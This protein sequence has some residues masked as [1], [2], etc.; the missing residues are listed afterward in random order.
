MGLPDRA[1][2]RRPGVQRLDLTKVR[3]TV[4]CNARQ[5]GASSACGASQLPIPRAGS[6]ANPLPP[7]AMTQPVDSWPTS[8]SDGPAYPAAELEHATGEE[9]HNAPAQG[10]APPPADGVDRSPADGINSH[11]TEDPSPGGNVWEPPLSDVGDSSEDQPDF[12]EGDSSVLSDDPGNDLSGVD[13]IRRG[14]ASSRF[15]SRLELS[16][17]SWYL[18]DSFPGSFFDVA[19]SLAEAPGT[20]HLF[21]TQQNGL[22]LAIS[23]AAPASQ[24]KVVLDLT[25]TTQGGSDCGLLG[26]AFHPEFG[27][28]GSPNRGFM[29][30]H[31]AYSEAPVQPQGA[32]VEPF[33]RTSSR[34]SRFTVNLDTLVAAPASEQI[35]IEQDDENLYHQ[36]GALLFHPQDGFL[37]LTVGDEGWYDCSFSNC[38]RIDKDLFS[39]VLRIDVDQ[40]GGNVSHPIPRQPESGITANYYIPN[41]NPFVGQPGV[42]EEFYALG[43]RSPH[44]M[45]HDP[46]D[47]LVLIGDVGQFL[48]EEVNLLATGANYQWNIREG[49]VA[50][51]G[52]TPSSPIGVWTDPVLE[53]ERAES[54]S[55]IGGYV[56][57]GDR[58]PELWVNTSPATSRPAT[59]GRYPTTSTARNSGFWGVSCSY[60][61][62]LACLRLA[63]TL[64]VSSTCFTSGYTR[65]ESSSVSWVKHTLPSNLTELGLFEAPGRPADADVLLPYGVQSPLWSDGAQKERWVAFPSGGQ[66]SFSANGPWGFPEGTIFVKHFSM[67][68]D[69]RFP[70]E[71]RPLETRFLVHGAS[72]GYYGV[73]YKW[74]RAGTRATLLR[75]RL[76]G[77]PGH[78]PSRRQR[79]ASALYVSESRRLPGLPQ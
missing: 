78:H 32:P 29:Y 43:L 2:P 57:R 76:G 25:A 49:T 77:K 44:R 69:E 8:E 70:A 48:R 68:L 34:L 56:Y 11:P 74:N 51:L 24:M 14:V 5:D 46:I 9:V 22:I 28:L 19:T 31:R 59:S 79:T 67:A 4:A 12:P 45:T 58:F 54:A 6:N 40:R 15:P 62:P 35:L 61:R 27:Q 10:G 42:L 37:Y 30:V 52:S 50:G 1:E 18:A 55:L 63:S 26:L 64:K 73:S 16:S 75:G 21:V 7:P 66:V 17:Q 23:K 53:L 60:K 39:G 41:D 71:R 20:Q 38:Q 3:E 65:S 36:G 33:T 13:S 47:N 72:D